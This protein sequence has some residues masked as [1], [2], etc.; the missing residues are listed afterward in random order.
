RT[1][2]PANIHSGNLLSGSFIRTKNETLA[3]RQA[4]TI[5]I[6]KKLPHRLPSLLEKDKKA[7]CK[8]R[9]FCRNLFLK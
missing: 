2:S 6:T 9:L 4:V 5:P 3:N 8:G 7:S 1:T